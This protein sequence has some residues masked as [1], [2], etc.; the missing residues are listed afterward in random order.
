MCTAV[1]CQHTVHGG[2]W[3]QHQAYSWPRIV[4]N[5]GGQRT[6][7]PW[8]GGCVPHENVRGQGGRH[9]ERASCWRKGNM[10]VPL[11]GW[12]LASGVQAGLQ[13]WL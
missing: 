5:P 12:R 7:L 1:C 3:H 11:G 6:A 8:A 13:L 2:L 9:R 10:W 4:H